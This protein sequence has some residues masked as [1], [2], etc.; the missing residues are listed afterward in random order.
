MTLIVGVKCSDGIV[1]GA[2]ST[3]TYST[4]FGQQS[5]IR[6]D[7]V[8]KLHIASEKLVVGV[9]GPV[10]LSQFY[11]DELDG[12]LSEK[13]FKIA[14]KSVADAKTDLS[15]RFWKHAGPM[16]DRAGVVARTVGSAAMIECNHASAVAF[17]IG[18]TPCLIQFST[19]CNG[20]EV[21]QELPFV[22]LGSGQ[23]PADTFLAFIRRI[24]WPTG[25][26]LPSLT[27]GQV[28][29]IWTLDE[30]IK[31]NPGGVGGEVKV[32]VLSKNNKG[33]WKCEFLSSEEMDTHRRMIADVEKGMLEAMRPKTT[34]PPT[35]IPEVTP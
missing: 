3:A 8:T 4:Q 18:E 30:V 2:D 19:Q 17:A 13:G 22:A 27:D 7:T 6:Q 29:T 32:V 26:G 1:L 25:S 5:T 16:W 24:F 28:A 33:H 34:P 14:W 9:S 11:S 20:E 10:S 12:C 15:K 23:P 21:T 35:P 31:S